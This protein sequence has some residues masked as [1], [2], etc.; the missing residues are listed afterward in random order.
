MKT[1]NDS[2]DILTFGIEKAPRGFINPALF[3]VRP[4][5]LKPIVSFT[6]GL[7][8]SDEGYIRDEYL[9]E[10]FGVDAQRKRIYIRKQDKE[11]FIGM[12]NMW[13]DGYM[14]EKIIEFGSFILARS[15]FKMD[16]PVPTTDRESNTLY[17]MWK[18]WK[19]AKAT[20]DL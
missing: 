16:N 13:L 19:E 10:L 9:L 2:I 1:N 6:D 17:G 4:K 12:M 5:K 8:V 15:I 14:K 18:Q 3:K 11:A 7:E 20:K